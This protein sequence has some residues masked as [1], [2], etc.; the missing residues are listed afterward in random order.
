MG[1]MH[2]LNPPSF[3]KFKRWVAMQPQRSERKIEQDRQQVDFVEH[4]IAEGLLP[5]TYDTYYRTARSSKLQSR[6]E[7]PGKKGFMDWRAQQG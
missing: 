7:L 6:W 4:L 2:V 5:A 3:N 1:P